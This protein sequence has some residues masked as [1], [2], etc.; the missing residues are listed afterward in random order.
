MTAEEELLAERDA[1]KARVAELEGERQE[2]K[3]QLDIAINV[4]E[5]ADATIRDLRNDLQR[6]AGLLDTETA[7]ALRSRESNVALR[8]ENAELKAQIQAMRETQSGEVAELKNVVSAYRRYV[9]SWDKHTSGTIADLAQLQGAFAAALTEPEGR[10]APVGEQ[11]E[12]AAEE[13]VDGP[14]MDAILQHSKEAFASAFPEAMRIMKLSTDEIL[15]EPAAD[16]GREPDCPDC[17]YGPYAR[18]HQ[19]CQ[20]QTYPYGSRGTTEIR[21]LGEELAADEGGE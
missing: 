10:T 6:A 11:P 16:E 5:M 18:C 13:N 19:H 3:H 17:G 21:T 4:S 2:D 8:A 15:A 9:R 20:T 14:I 1:L 7:R 12:P